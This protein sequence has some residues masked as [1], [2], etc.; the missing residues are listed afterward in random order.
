VRDVLTEG[1]PCRHPAKSSLTLTVPVRQ[2]ALGLFLCGKKIR[3]IRA[4]SQPAGC[5][6]VDLLG[7]KVV[8]GLFKFTV[9]LL[10]NSMGGHALETCLRGAG[11]DGFADLESPTPPVLIYLA[12]GKF[13]ALAVHL[14]PR[15]TPPKMVET[16]TG[17][18]P[19]QNRTA[20]EISG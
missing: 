8:P 20:F 11:S 12:N 7:G 17:S 16:E 5:L 18:G 15:I 9:D 10:V 19:V 4:G 6:F 14:Q 2:P 13:N 3:R 1:G